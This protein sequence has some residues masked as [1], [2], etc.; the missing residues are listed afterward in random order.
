MTS[1]FADGA[2]F[3]GTNDWIGF[4]PYLDSTSGFSFE[5]YYYLSNSSDARILLDLAYDTTWNTSTQKNLTIFTTVSGSAKIRP[6]NANGSSHSYFSGVSVSL[7]TWIHVVYTRD[8]AGTGKVYINGTL[9][10]T[11]S[12]LSLIHI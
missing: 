6:V 9:S 1:R 10:E 5:I 2:T 3:D 7:N 12:P 4:S 8:A 11:L